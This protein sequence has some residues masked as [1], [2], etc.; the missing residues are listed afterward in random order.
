MFDRDF[1]LPIL[2][3]PWEDAPEV[4]KILSSHG[5]DED[6]VAHV[7]LHFTGLYISWL[8]GGSFGVCDISKHEMPDGS[9]VYIGA[10][11]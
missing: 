1:K 5:G 10:H 11:S 6:W 8:E 2:V 3:W 7:P 4:L 9:I